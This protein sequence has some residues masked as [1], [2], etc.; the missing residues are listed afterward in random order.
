M[1]KLLIFAALLAAVV[2]STAQMKQT[3]SIALLYRSLA[4]TNAE[5]AR[6]TQQTRETM[7]LVGIGGV[8]MLAGT[9]I[10]IAATNN[11]NPT[12]AAHLAKVGAG[13]AIVGAGFIAA[14]L[15]TMPK[16]VSIDHRGFVFGLPFK[17]K[18][19]KK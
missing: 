14:S 17:N 2:T 5:L 12:N 9:A 18:P 11:E 19:K 3:D 8:S 13:F 1:K 4:Q 7:T 6:V 10:S 15:F 16:N